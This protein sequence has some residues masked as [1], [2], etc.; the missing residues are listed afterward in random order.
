MYAYMLFFSWEQYHNVNNNCKC[1][2]Y[3]KRKIVNA[4]NNKEKLM[5]ALRNRNA[6]STTAHPWCGGYSTSINA[7]GVWRQGLEF[8]SLRGSFTCIYT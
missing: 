5:D 4:I 3:Y 6:T 2:F 1:Y 7:C 8:K